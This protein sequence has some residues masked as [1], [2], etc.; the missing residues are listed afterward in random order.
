MT[1]HIDST[2]E[3]RARE[4]VKNFTDVMWHVAVYVIVNG[5]LWTLDLVQGGGLQWAFWPT[6]FWGIGL[7]FHIASYFLDES[8]LQSRRYQRYLEEERAD[9]ARHV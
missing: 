9:D 5:L 4:R 2:P 1:G 6:I 7:A 8:G 3:A